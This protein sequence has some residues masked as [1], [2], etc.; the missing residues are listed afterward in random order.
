MFFSFPED[1]RWN[2]ERGSRVWRPDRRVRERGA[3]RARCLPA[4]DGVSRPKRAS[5]PTRSSTRAFERIAERKLRNRQ[6]TDDGNVEI[7]GRDLRDPKPAHM[8]SW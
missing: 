4:L 7:T 5:R 3:R 2:T 8:R 6:L 1:A